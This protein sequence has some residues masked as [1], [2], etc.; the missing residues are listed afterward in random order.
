[1]ATTESASIQLVLEFDQ[2]WKLVQQLSSTKQVELLDK[3]QDK[4]K[5]NQDTPV[6][7]TQKAQYENGVTPAQ[8][9]QET[10][11]VINYFAVEE[12]AAADGEEEELTEEEFHQRLKE[13]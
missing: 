5:K 12:E 3:L 11:L 6:P 8:L 1:M 7:N 10:P 2:I 9:V 4:L 13:M